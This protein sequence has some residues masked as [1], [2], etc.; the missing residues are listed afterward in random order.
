MLFTEL[1]QLDSCKIC[2][3]LA[4]AQVHACIGRWVGVS[5]CVHVCVC[6][7]VNVCMDV[8]VCVCVCVCVC[9]YAHV[10]MR[11]CVQ[12]C[13]HIRI[14]AFGSVFLIRSY[15][16]PNGAGRCSLAQ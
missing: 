11:V 9:V 3:C 6:V 13:M 12:L 1:M 2:V 14:Y 16:A 8:D 5:A 10:C 7:D 15:G 4:S